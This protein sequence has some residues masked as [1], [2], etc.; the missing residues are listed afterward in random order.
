MKWGYVDNNCSNI[1]ILCLFSLLRTGPPVSPGE[2]QW[3]WIRA[4]HCSVSKRAMQP[5][6]L[7]I[8]ALRKSENQV[9]VLKAQCPFYLICDLREKKPYENCKKCIRWMLHPSQFFKCFWSWWWWFSNVIEND[10]ALT[11]ITQELLYQALRNA[12]PLIYLI[13][14]QWVWLEAKLFL[15]QVWVF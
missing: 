15:C 6:C 2:T 10:G 11:A 3:M 5:L 13:L 12:S 1:Q 9:N 8:V 7:S 4:F 14:V